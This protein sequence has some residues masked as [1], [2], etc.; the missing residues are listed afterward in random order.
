LAN[1]EH[2][3]DIVGYLAEIDNVQRPA[4]WRRLI[5]GGVLPPYKSRSKPIAR[6]TWRNLTELEHQRQELP[7]VDRDPCPRCGVRGDVG[8]GHSRFP[9]VVSF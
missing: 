5:A 3:Q 7:R 8:C 2:P 6:R 1:G 4:I 9:L